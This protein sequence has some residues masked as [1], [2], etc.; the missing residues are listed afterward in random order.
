MAEHHRLEHLLLGQ[1]LGFQFDHHH[2][3]LGAGD[4]E[5]ERAFGHLVEHRVQDELAADEADA[6]RRDGAEEGHARQ[7]QRRRGGDQRQDVGVVLHVMGEHV[8]DDLRLVLEAFARTAGGWAGRSG[9]R[10]ASPSRWGAP[11]A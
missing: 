5:V 7:R 6:G 4:D 1:L 3:V 11:R 10:S 9:G 2:R 8:D